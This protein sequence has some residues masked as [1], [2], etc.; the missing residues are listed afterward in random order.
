MLAKV[1][2]RLDHQSATTLLAKRT[3]ESLQSFVSIVEDL[4]SIKMTKFQEKKFIVFLGLTKKGQ[5]N[6]DRIFR[7][8]K[9]K[10]KKVKKGGK[11]EE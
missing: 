8:K 2:E 4:K 7:R 11:V 10:S 3:Y 9:D 1:Q 5:E 6:Y